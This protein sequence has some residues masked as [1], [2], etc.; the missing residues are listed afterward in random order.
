MP[1]PYADVEEVKRELEAGAA[2]FEMDD[3]E[4]EALLVRYL[5]DESAR[6]DAWAKPELVKQ[7]HDAVDYSGVHPVIREGVVRLTRARL[8]RI[9][10]DILGSDRLASGEQREYRTPRSVARE[11]VEEMRLA[12]IYKDSEGSFWG[13]TL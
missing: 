12:G 8:M 10:A 7:W 5:T 3:G 6:L 2:D 4:F 11:V 1:T 9:H 13:V